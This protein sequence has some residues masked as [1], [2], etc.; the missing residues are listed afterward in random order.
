[1]LRPATRTARF[2]RQR[3]SGGVRRAANR[4]LQDRR[5]TRADSQLF[6]ISPPSRPPLWTWWVAGRR[7]GSVNSVQNILHFSE[8]TAG[9]W[10]TA[11]HGGTIALKQDLRRPAPIL[12]VHTALS[13]TDSGCS[14]VSVEEASQALVPVLTSALFKPAGVLFRERHPSLDL[15]PVPAHP[16]PAA[17]SPKCAAN[18]FLV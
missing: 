4:R 15:P 7:A 8:V 13:F 14:C 1:M 10:R 6:R 11:W 5:W 2:A 18:P 9:A 17:Q 16:G 3:P 12:V